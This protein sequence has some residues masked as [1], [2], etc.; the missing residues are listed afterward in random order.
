MSF[1]N[2]HWRNGLIILVFTVIGFFIGGGYQ[3]LSTPMDEILH[4]HRAQ[5]DD[6]IDD[7]QA[8][9]ISFILRGGIGAV[10]GAGISSVVLYVATKRK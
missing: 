2:K 6:I 5:G 4:P 3:L 7:I 8:Y 9:I 1:L 10:A